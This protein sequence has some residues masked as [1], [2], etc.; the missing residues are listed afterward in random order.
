MAAALTGGLAARPAGSSRPGRLLTWIA[1]ALITLA[2]ITPWRPAVWSG[3]SGKPG[4]AAARPDSRLA[5]VRPARARFAPG[6]IG[7][8]CF[9]C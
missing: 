2:L 7:H 6:G 4:I 9:G 1:L 5:A 3:R 8:M